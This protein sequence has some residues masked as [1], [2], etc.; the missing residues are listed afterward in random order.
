[1]LDGAVDLRRELGIAAWFDRAAQRDHRLELGEDRV[2]VVVLERG[3]QR[4]TPGLARAA[5]IAGALELVVHVVEGV[6]DRASQRG[7]VVDEGIV[8]LVAAARVVRDRR[9]QLRREDGL[10]RRQ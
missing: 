10:D 2:A 1:A 4:L 6:G 7:L 3:Q 8:E 5:R 9:G